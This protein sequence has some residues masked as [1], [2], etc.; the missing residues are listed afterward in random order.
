MR[1]WWRVLRTVIQDMT[2]D[3]ELP[4]D[5][6]LRIRPPERENSIAVR[7]TQTLDVDQVA[8][9]LQDAKAKT[10]A[11]YC[12]IA[13]LA[14]TGIRQ[15]ELFG[16]KWDSVDFARGELVIRR[17]VSAGVLTETTKTKAQR[18]V[19]M[20]PLLV[21]A[22]R[23]HRQSLI[24]EQHP[25]LPSVL[26]FPSRDGK[27]RTSTSLNVA[28]RT[29]STGDI[30]IGAQVLRRSMNSNLLRQAV[31]RLTIRSI[32]GHTTEQM[33]ERYYGASSAD[34]QAAVL[35]LPISSEG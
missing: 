28:F 32:M 4:R 10:P 15:G 8:T 3:M 11:R 7:E 5:P 24:A 17:A 26:V 22:L 34:K 1:C 25:G 19:P 12:E 31:D 18:T 2:A 20:H 33:T 9:L 29:L 27:P 21:D 13:I 6:T 16:L 30:R 14:L 35:R 23:E